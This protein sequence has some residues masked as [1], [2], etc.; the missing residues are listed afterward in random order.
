MS[1]RR[2]LWIIALVYVIEGFPMGVYGNVWPVF[3]RRNDVSLAEIGLLAGLSIAWSA[4]VLWSPLVDRFGERRRWI[5]GALLV[6]AACLML[7]LGA[8]AAR[9]GALLW[10]AMTLYC[11]ASATQ[12]I[13]IDAYTIGLVDRGEEGPAN[14][15]RVT[16]YRAGMI[17]AGGGLL[18]LPRWVGWNGTFAAAALASAAMAAVVFVCPRVEVPPESRRDTFRSLRR[19]LD[20]PG[21]IPVAGFILLY[22]VGDRAL[23]PMIHPFWVD[24]GF[25]NEEIATVSTTLGALALV[26]GAIVGGLVVARTGIHRSLWILGLLALASNLAYAVA[27]AVPESGAAGVYAASVVESFCG[28]LATAAFMSLLMRVCEKEH[29][30]VQYALL[31]ALYAL[32]GSAVAMPSGALTERLGYATYFAATA[33]F[34]LPAFAFLPGVRSWLEPDRVSVTPAAGGER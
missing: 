31:T 23:G 12:D 33:V 26:A 13:A 16:A 2:K 24:R 6:M 9:I 18:F 7:F 29:A 34:A 10:V 3:F 27:A 28:G 22:R 5:A 15:V 4:K 20:R 1:L 8:P 19:W 30:A 17:A 14:S 25:S 32:A 11:V 21:V